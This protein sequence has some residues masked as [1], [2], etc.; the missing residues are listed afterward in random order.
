MQRSSIIATVVAAGGIL[1]AGSVASVA[2]INASATSSPEVG[3]VTLVADEEPVTES[4]GELVPDS[5]DVPPA[6]QSTDVPT[7]LPSVESGALPS[8]PAVGGQSAPATRDG[9]RD[10]DPDDEAAPA[11]NPEP[12]ASSKPRATKEAQPES[13]IS[14][15][16]ARSLVLA[17]GKGVAVLGVSK[18]TRGGLQTWAVRIERSNGEVLTGYVDRASGVVVDWVVNSGPTPAPQSTQNADDDDR[19][20]EYE[21]DSDDNSGKGSSEE[22]DEDYDDDGEDDDD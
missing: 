14:A 18:A 6:D 20:E 21:D 4:T 2:V 5:V 22:A 7:D 3:T 17:E 11:R 16:E 1:I 8:V 15:D 19:E 13:S 12:T 9:A 10:D